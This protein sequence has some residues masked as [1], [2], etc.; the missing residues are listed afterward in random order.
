VSEQQGTDGEPPAPTARGSVERTELSRR[1][2]AQARRAAESK[3]T[4]PHSYLA[5]SVE[6]GGETDDGGRIAQL[7]AAIATALTEHPG[8]NAAYRD[9]AIER[10][11]RVNLGFTVETPEGAQVPTVFD[12]DQLAPKQI[13]ARIE[14]L[15]L[16]A[17]AGSLAAPDLSGSTFTVTALSAGADALAPIVAPGQCGHIGIGRARAAVLPDGGSTRSAILVELTLSCDQRAVRPSAA[18]AFLGR[19]AELVEDPGARD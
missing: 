10:Y 18:A 9:G 16:G 17:L 19:A 11:S 4:I 13:E 3:A 15:T 6:L 8:L 12:A 1:A 2:Q 14:R 5:R 7:L